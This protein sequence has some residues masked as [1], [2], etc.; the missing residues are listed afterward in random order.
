MKNNQYTPLPLSKIISER[1]P[2]LETEMWWYHIPESERNDIAYRGEV[3]LFDDRYGFSY[4]G[5][6]TH[7]TAKRRH[8]IEDL[9]RKNYRTQAYSFTDCLWAIEMLG[10]KEG[11]RREDNKYMPYMVQHR[12]LDKYLADHHTIGENT[13]AYLTELF[14]RV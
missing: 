2:E 9:V 8:E 13:I 14:T 4:S 1:L 12:L 3:K 6:G 7:Y 5:A 11:K 10:E